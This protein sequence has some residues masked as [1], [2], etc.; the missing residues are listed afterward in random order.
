MSIENLKVFLLC[1]LQRLTSGSESS[2]M[3]SLG[4][5][6]AIRGDTSFGLQLAIS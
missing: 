5:D 2:N 1:E 4:C 6:W 3:F